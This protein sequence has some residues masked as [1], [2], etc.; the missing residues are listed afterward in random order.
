MP[1]VNYQQDP[2]EAF[3][4]GNF[5]DE[6][7]RSIY[8]SD[9]AEARRFVNTMPGRGSLKSQIASESDSLAPME[10]PRIGHS[11]DR[12][13][14]YD[15]D[16]DSNVASDAGPRATPQQV[17]Q[18]ALT[19][20][21]AAKA[22]PSGQESVPPARPV[23]VPTGKSST[24]TPGRDVEN[25][26]GTSREALDARKQ[27]N[28][29]AATNKDGRVKAGY[30]SQIDAQKQLRDDKLEE[31]ANKKI[32]IDLS[33]MNVNDASLEKDKKLVPNQLIEGMST[34]EKIKMTILSGLFGGWAAIGGRQN[35][36]MKS[37]EKLI[38]DDIERQKLDIQNGRQNRSN[39]IAHYQALGNDART[40][41]VL[42]R[43]D[44]SN[45]LK[46]Y[47]ELTAQQTAATD[48]E[49]GRVKALNAQLDQ[50]QANF[51]ARL[52][53]EA[54]PRT[55]V[56]T[57]YSDPKV[58]DASNEVKQLE[59]AQK[60]TE[61]QDA[62]RVAELLNAGKKPDDP[63]YRS[64]TPNQVKEFQT[65]AEKIS[66]AVEPLSQMEFSVNNLVKSLDPNAEIV[67][68]QVKWS[69]KPLKGVGVSDKLTNII[70][71]SESERDSVIRARDDLKDLYTGLRTGAS[72]TIIQDKI[73]DQLSGGG[74]TDE[75]VTKKQVQDAI[76]RLNKQRA[77]RMKGYRREA[78]T[79]YEQ[80][81]SSQQ[82]SPDPSG[83]RVPAS[84]V[85]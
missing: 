5:I 12:I 39:R 67:N 40:S 27:A 63:G 22:R 13:A 56:N 58:R 81:N 54:Q 83:G 25:D 77:D 85:Q 16:P 71:F 48:E 17:A 69:G 73:Y 3:G 46:A 80:Q 9:P 60:Q 6:N 50:D 82:T 24:Y 7:G 14:E 28:V 42:A 53:V 61:Q 11:D 52:R 76:S 1:I 51:E 15:V 34:G 21:E 66:K 31:A 20:T 19:A 57:I 45:A 29:D 33:N 41:Y 65:D 64:Y 10:D 62:N 74:F 32:D 44:A 55:S 47:T 79:L 18:K 8:T 43:Q 70:P 75:A 68:G 37:V 23:L 84:P 49:L 38:D 2:D 36:Y 72:A 78:V 30:Q 35:G 26:I 4:T 59:L